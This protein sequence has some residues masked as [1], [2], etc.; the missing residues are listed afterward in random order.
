MFRHREDI[1]RLL[2]RTKHIGKSGLTTSDTA[3]LA[4]QTEAKDVAKPSAAEELLRSFDNQLLV[5]Q[6]VLITAFLNEKG[7]VDP[8]ERDRVLTRYLASSNILRRFDAI[9]S[10]IFGSQ[11]Q[12]LHMLNQRAPEGVPTSDLEGWYQVGVATSPHMYGASGENFSF[13]QW[14]SFLYRNTLI[15]VV[16]TDSHLTLFGQEFLKYLLQNS[17]GTDRIG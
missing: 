2:G 5:E 10:G 12:A 3:A 17:Y 1:S 8:H 14:L 13:A 11:L 9:Y 4:T 6:E 15:A 7:I 16:G